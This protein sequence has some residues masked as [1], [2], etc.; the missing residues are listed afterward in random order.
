MPLGLAPRLVSGQL[1]VVTK[2][3]SGVRCASRAISRTAAS[4]AT[5]AI[6]CGSHMTALVPCGSTERANSEGVS[7]LDSRWMWLSMKP[8]AA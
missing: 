3:L 5:L 6:S 1:G 4:P 7:M 8:G 2:V